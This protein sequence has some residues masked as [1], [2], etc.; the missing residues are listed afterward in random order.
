MNSKTLASRRVEFWRERLVRASLLYSDIVLAIVVWWIAALLRNVLV[1]GTISETTFAVLVPG[2]LGWL[3]LRYAMGLYPGYAL[4]DVEELRRQVY[5]VLGAASVSLMFAFF[6]QVGD[7]V[8]RLVLL[9]GF[10]GI[11]ISSPLT[12]Q[13]AKWIL[14]KAGLWGKPVV[15][16]G[17][18]EEGRALVRILEGEWGFGLRPVALFQGSDESTED[19]ELSEAAKLSREHGVDTIMLVIPQDGRERL[20]RISSQ[21]SYS[22]RHVIILPDMGGVINSAV[23]VRNFLGNFGVELKHNLLDPWARLLKRTL[24][25]LGVVVGGLV[26]APFLLTVTVLIKLDSSGPIFYG[27]WRRGAGGRQFRCWKFRTMR[28]DAELLLEEYLRT[29]PDIKAEWE[30]NY[31]LQN[32]PRITRIGSFLRKTSLDELPQLWNV[33]LGEM[34]LVGPRPMLE[35]ELSSYGQTYD[36]YKRVPP[37]ITGFWQVS[38]RS[39]VGYEE[40]VAMNAYYVR[41][42]SVWLDIVIL[43]RTVRSVLV[44]RGAR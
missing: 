5:A 42:W 40:R 41:D 29:S 21:A 28:P 22:F 14:K 2:M 3:T 23:A 32:D 19:R 35:T 20:E 44:S 4:S 11:L 30:Q 43:A 7:F 13:G 12:R 24:D 10:A 34:S 26:I 39:D 16:V 36:L 9:L 33:L 6:L 15:I 37:G 18:G 17:S 27:S 31:K 8:S 1:G 38:G 25:L